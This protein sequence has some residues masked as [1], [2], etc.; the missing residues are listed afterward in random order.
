MAPTDKNVNEV[1]DCAVAAYGAAI[2]QD[3]PLTTSMFEL[4]SEYVALRL[5]V[6]ENTAQLLFA[7]RLSVVR[8]QRLLDSS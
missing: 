1:L 5:H 4:M 2:E 8:A 7:A 3:P 6:T